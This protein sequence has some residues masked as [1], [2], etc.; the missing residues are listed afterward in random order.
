MET[1]TPRALSA[2][3]GG[4][5]IAGAS[6]SQFPYVSDAG[7]QGHPKGV[8]TTVRLF[9]PDGTRTLSLGI[10]SLFSDAHYRSICT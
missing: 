2:T 9:Q 1:L 10:R 6:A 5:M 8:P 7:T 3:V 4:D